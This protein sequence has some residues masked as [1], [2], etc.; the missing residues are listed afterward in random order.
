MITICV[1]MVCL[2]LK[3]IVLVFFLLKLLCDCSDIFCSDTPQLITRKTLSDELLWRGVD[4]N[5]SYKE[6]IN[7]VYGEYANTD[8]DY[9]YK[10]KL[11]VIYRLTIIFKLR[12]TKFLTLYL[13]M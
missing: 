11:D 8:N 12:M 6:Y 7:L 10:L 1:I 2:N 4:R 3:L 13:N 9:F 5:D